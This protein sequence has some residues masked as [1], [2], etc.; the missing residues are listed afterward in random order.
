MRGACPGVRGQG[1]NGG[2]TGSVRHGGEAWS[3]AGAEHHCTRKVT[4]ARAASEDSGAPREGGR[5]GGRESLGQS[6]GPHGFPETRRY[7]CAQRT[8]NHRKEP[9][10]L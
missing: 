3:A 4:C 6:A 9:G 5:G 10:C 8:L 7:Y 1:A 2:R